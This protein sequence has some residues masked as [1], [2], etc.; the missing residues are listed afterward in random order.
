MPISIEVEQARHAAEDASRAKSN[1]LA[2]MSHEIRTPMNGVIGMNALLLETPLNDDQR[3]FADAV[4]Q[5]AESLLSLLN[6]IL[7]ISKLEAGGVELEYL[8]FELEELI[9]DAVELMT[10]KAAEKGLEIGVAVAREARGRFIG[11][12]PRLRRILLNLLSNAV[13]FTERGAIL[14]EAHAAESAGA[15]GLLRI[16]VA[17]SGIGIA[18]EQRDRLSV[19]G[20]PSASSWSS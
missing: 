5:S 3:Q 20:W 15:R 9:E 17:D 11:D 16:E 7:D 2:T 19:S 12:A 14:V 13:K 4:R 18:P 10:P 1:F 6:D 8:P